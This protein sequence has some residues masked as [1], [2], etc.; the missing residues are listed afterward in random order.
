MRN[1]KSSTPSIET[2]KMAPGRTRQFICG[3]PLV[4]SV[5][6]PNSPNVSMAAWVECAGPSISCDGLLE[7]AA[8]VQA[9]RHEGPIVAGI[10]HST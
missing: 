4:A 7:Y 8:E 3:S 10:T 6:E 9:Y 5:N 2:Y 1:H